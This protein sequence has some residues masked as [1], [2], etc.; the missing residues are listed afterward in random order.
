MYA[1]NER[2]TEGHTHTLQEKRFSLFLRRSALTCPSRRRSAHTWRREKKDDLCDNDDRCSIEIVTVLVWTPVYDSLDRVWAA[3][4][5]LERNERWKTREWYSKNDTNTVGLDFCRIGLYEN[6]CLPV[7]NKTPWTP[8]HMTPVRVALNTMSSSKETKRDRVRDQRRITWPRS[9]IGN[10]SIYEDWKEPRY[11][12]KTCG[13]EDPHRYSI[14]SEYS[15]TWECWG[16]DDVGSV[17]NSIRHRARDGWKEMFMSWPDILI[18][19]FFR[20][21]QGRS[22]DASHTVRQESERKAV[23]YDFRYELD[24]WWR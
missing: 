24:W 8:V 10:L 22:D 13:R 12:N 15:R 18:S 1:S 20:P 14:F 4:E 9:I 19:P 17:Q 16:E 2:R 3:K 11:Q 21:S 6:G 5:Q 7:Q 23:R